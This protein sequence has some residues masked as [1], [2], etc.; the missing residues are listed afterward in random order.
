MH[1]RI[2]TDKELE[3]VSLPDSLCLDPT[4]VLPRFLGTHI[5]L[6]SEDFAV[7]IGYKQ[8]YVYVM[9]PVLLIASWKLP[10]IC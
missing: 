6:C 1:C 5:T 10:N 8:V 3:S 9:S 2:D 7:S 4:N